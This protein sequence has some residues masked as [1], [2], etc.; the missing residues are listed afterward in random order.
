MMIDLHNHI[1]P[2]IDDGA[3]T[4]EDSL[5]MARIAVKEGIHTI[6]AT[7]HHRNSYYDNPTDVVLEKVKELNNRLNEERIPLVILPGQEPALHSDILESIQQ[8]SILTLNQTQYLFIE[9]PSVH[10][11]RYTGQILFELQNKG[12]IPIIVH[13]ERNK[14]IMEQPDI[15]YQLIKRG[16]LAQLTASSICG[17]FGKNIKKFSQQLIEANLVHFI[18]SDA[19][20][21][22][23]RTFNMAKAYNEI[24]SLYGLELAYLYKENAELLIKGKN[25]YKDEPQQVKKKRLLGIF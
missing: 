15:L 12:M 5:N 2:G 22:H 25:I 18:A 14:G 16:A 6:I 24:Q 11:P 10:V 1:L 19:H 17:V 23:N 21:T 8:G 9:L 7:P 4:L 3:K 20:N 13:P